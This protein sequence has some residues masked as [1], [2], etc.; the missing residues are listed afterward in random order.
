MKK[1]NT[2]EIKSLAISNTEYFALTGEYQDGEYV[3]ADG[4]YYTPTFS[5]G[6]QGDVPFETA[7]PEKK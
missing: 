4:K 3:S 5:G 1:W 2:P 6:Y 7:S